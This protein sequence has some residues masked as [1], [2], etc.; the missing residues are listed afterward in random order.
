MTKRCRSPDE[1]T[2]PQKYTCAGDRIIWTH[3][4]ETGEHSSVF[5]R[6]TGEERSAYEALGVGSVTGDGEGKD[7]GNPSPWPDDH[8]GLAG[9]YKWV[10]MEE[11]GVP[12]NL[13]LYDDG[14]GVFDMLGAVESVRYD[15]TTMQTSGEGARP[16]KYTYSDGT[17][18]WITV[19]SDEEEPAVFVKLTAEELAA[20]ETRGIGSTEQAPQ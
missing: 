1:G 2:V 8:G 3:A 9:V 10:G 16:Q 7:R 6:L 5:V 14:T 19:G 20:Y 4:D 12:A 15:D 18:L 11:I 17:L 13:I